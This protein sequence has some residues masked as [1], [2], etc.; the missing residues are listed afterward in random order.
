M[1]KNK[2]KSGILLHITSLPG[3]EEIGTIID[4]EAFADSLIEAGQ[5]MWQ[6]LPINPTSYSNSPFLGPSVF[7][8]NPALIN[9]AKLAQNGDLLNKEYNSHIT[10]WN[11]QKKQGIDFQFLWK[12]KLGFDK[13]KSHSILKTAF[14]GFRER[15][16]SARAAGFKLFCKNEEYWLDDYAEFMA[17][18][19]VNG[20]SRCW[21]TWRH[22]HRDRDIGY[23]SYMP[24]ELIDFFKYTQF[25]FH[26]QMTELK[27]YLE[28]KKIELIGD[29]PIYPGYDSAD[30]WANRKLFQLDQKGNMQ[31]VSGVPPDYFSSTGQRWGSPVYKWGAIGTESDH[32]KL[33]HWWSK[34]FLRLY[35]YLDT[36]KIDHFI[37]FIRYA[38]VQ[39]KEKDA[40]NAKWVKGPGKKLFKYLETALGS[41]LSV[42]AE[43]LGSITPNVKNQ[44]EQLGYPGMKIFQFSDPGNNHS[45]HLPSTAPK[46]SVMYTGTHDNATIS[47][48]LHNK[49]GAKKRNDFMNYLNRSKERDLYF[50]IIDIILS[51]KSDR[52]IFPMQDILGLGKTA[53]MNNPSKKIGLWKWRM[54]IID[55]K[56]FLQLSPKLKQLTIKNGRYS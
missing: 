20:F 18:K 35:Q 16:S 5:T 9:L 25:I 14:H 40:R 43:D 41:K 30:A 11:K 2:R 10:L 52:V 12:E 3:K 56:K 54:N 24:G 48:F 17:L 47:E 28:K 21:N 15:A 31:W 4:G 42:I 8:G 45:D 7:A 44:L 19:A 13:V 51:A 39:A 32:T 22:T 34:R 49:I 37:G 36:I 6:I 1:Q 23:N 55:V 46:N 53:R 26:E 29:I 33:F 27:K 38:R 50:R